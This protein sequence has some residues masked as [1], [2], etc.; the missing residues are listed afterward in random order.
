MTEGMSKG[1]TVS[2]IVTAMVLCA[3]AY[4]SDSAT[5]MSGNCGLCL[6]SPN[7]WGVPQPWNWISNIAVLALCT[8]GISMLNR[9]YSLT[10][11]TATFLPGIFI[12]MSASI[13]WIV[14]ELTS[15]TIL[16]A[17]ML[18]NMA[19][20]CS[21]YRQRNSTQEIFV[22]A[23]LLS[24][25]SMIQYTF[26]L[27]IV[28]V[29]IIGIMFKCMHIRELL[30][31]LLGLVAPY[32]VAI[33]FGLISPYALAMPS[34]TNLFNGYLPDNMLLTGLI[35]IGCTGVVGM[36]LALY[37]GIKLYAG[38]TRRRLFNMAINVLGLYCLLC[39]VFDSDNLTAYIVTFFVSVSF[40]WAN[41][42]ALWHP[43]KPGI[44]ALGISLAY[45]A[46]FIVAIA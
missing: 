18:V 35:N 37:N 9:A 29:I 30:A 42:F 22:V 38:N 7:L 24:L 33:G 26:V 41:L 45:V 32:W 25:G 13:P 15:S 27:M 36:I 34:F 44:W 39:M 20:L 6:P 8:A 31:L 43:R 28:P 46:C 1:V 2:V 14:G 16:A 10:P 11:G 12:L 23:T 4:V 3:I 19:L 17:V 40:Q 5:V 21:C